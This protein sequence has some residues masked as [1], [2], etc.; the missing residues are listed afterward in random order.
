MADM[1]AAKRL[2]MNLGLRDPDV[3]YAYPKKDGT[4]WYELDN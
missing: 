2:K 3:P 1:A 4:E